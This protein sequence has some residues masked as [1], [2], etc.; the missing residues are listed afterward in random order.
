[1]IRL[2]P[3]SLLLIL[4]FVLSAI[5]CRSRTADI[6]GAWYADDQSIVKRASPLSPLVDFKEDGSCVF[7]S[8]PGKWKQINGDQIAVTLSKSS[9][10]WQMM[11]KDPS[12]S[13]ETVLTLSL[14]KEEVLTLVEINGKTW[15][16]SPVRLKRKP[17]E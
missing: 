11:A 13:R 16:R 7:L 4:I 15:K 2:V 6:V 9:S 17:V 12:P 10:Y 8:E 1:M 5:G 14:S 3:L